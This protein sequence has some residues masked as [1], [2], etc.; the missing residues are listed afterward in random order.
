MR[1]CVPATVT[2]RYS[3]EAVEDIRAQAAAA[4]AAINE[5]GAGASGQS[6]TKRPRSE[7]GSDDDSDAAAAQEPAVKKTYVSACTVL[8]LRVCVC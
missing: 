5:H 8:W 3:P 4:K 6:S 1:G 7:S 2:A